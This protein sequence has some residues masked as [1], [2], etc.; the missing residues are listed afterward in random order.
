MTFDT[1]ISQLITTLGLPVGL[2]ILRTSAIM[3]VLPVF[4]DQS[5]PP[6]V[7]LVMGLVT[8]FSL[9][10]VMGNEV[11]VPDQHIYRLIIIE[12]VNGILIGTLFRYFV[13]G[14]QTAGTIAAQ[15]FSIAQTNSMMADAPMPALGQFLLMGA[16]ALLLHSGFATQVIVILKNSYRTVPLGVL[17][18]PAWLIDHI[19]YLSDFIFDM[20]LKLAL[21]FCTAALLYNLIL[22][23]ANRVMPQL[24]V[25]LVGAPAGMLAMLGILTAASPIIIDSWVSSVMRFSQGGLP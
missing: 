1:T 16:L 15:S 24:M 20:A 9:A 14:L 17:P 3:M 10:G 19:L 4:G 8:G 2:I 11:S 25:M 6:R 7:K 22:G 5:I 12:V 23:A 18:T 21:P 13:L